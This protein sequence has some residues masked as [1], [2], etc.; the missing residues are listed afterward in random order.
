MII[1][2]TLQP[3]LEVEQKIVAA[4]CPGA[5]AD[6]IASFACSSSIAQPAAM[7]ASSRF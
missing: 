4:V 7:T 2:V 6:A 1:S 3:W 5:S